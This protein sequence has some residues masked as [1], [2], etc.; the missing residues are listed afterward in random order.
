MNNILVFSEPIRS[1]KSTLLLN[2]IIQYK[3][4][5]GVICP[6]IAGK[7]KLYIINEHL[8]LPL[9]VDVGSTNNTLQAGRFIFNA[10]SFK[11]AGESLLL[12]DYNVPSY[13]LI[14]EIG[15]LE[16]EK[17]QGFEPALTRIIEHYKS[18]Q[19]SDKLIL[20]IRDYLL[21]DALMKYGLQDATI[22]K[23]D[24][25]EQ[26][27]SQVKTRNT[28]PVIGLVMCGGKSSRMGSPK[29]LLKYHNKPQYIMVKNLL[30]P[31]CHTVQIS[32][33]HEQVDWF[34]Q[35]VVLQFDDDAYTQNG[36]VAAL[37]T[38][39]KLNEGNAYI[40]IGCDYPALNANDINLLVQT[41]QTF[42]KSCCF[43]NS[44]NME[45]PLLAFYHPNDLMLLS[46]FYHSG[47]YSLGRFLKYI[48]AVKIGAEDETTIKSYDTPEAFML[49]C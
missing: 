9:E 49:W 47:Q 32:C 48:N 33:K 31:F 22:I 26:Q 5:K 21:Q 13:M 10:D 19:T 4:I 25:F 44:E 17:K 1:G 2:W 18:N 41:G 11:R 27:I 6:D 46:E 28:Y 42:N 43:V 35:G 36:P 16:M 40:L 12:E 15:K 8:L 37:L 30:E 24:F 45:E 38:A 34:E 14:D 29:A 20:V 23:K 7:R 39:C 3:N